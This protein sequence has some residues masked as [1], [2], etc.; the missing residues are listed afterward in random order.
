MKIKFIEKI[1]DELQEEKKANELD[2]VIKS[3]LELGYKGN[4]YIDDRDKI[5][6]VLYLTGKVNL[7]RE[8][9]IFFFWKRRNCIEIKH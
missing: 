3:C 8:K 9:R 1:K 2:W 6:Q 7:I 4:G 5:Y